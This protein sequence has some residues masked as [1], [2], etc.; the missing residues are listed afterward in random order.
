[1][2]SAVAIAPD[3]SRLYLTYDEWQAPFQ[4]DEAAPRPMQG[5]FRTAPLAA[6]VPG[7]WTTVDRGTSGDA[8]GSSANSLVDEF[9]GDY[10]YVAAAG[11]FGVAVWNDTRND[12]NCPAVDAYRQSLIE[13]A[14]A[15][16]E[17]IAG[18]NDENDDPHAQAP[19]ASTPN[20]AVSCPTTFGNSDIY[21]ATAP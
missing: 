8:R 20:P 11:A 1:M 13:Q 18:A 5:V 16:G 14:T 3:A 9:L 6:G 10:N 21:A 15:S 7:A 2:Y 19:A 17:S 12:V 4:T